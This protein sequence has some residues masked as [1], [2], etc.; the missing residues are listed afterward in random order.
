MRF[1]PPL[2]NFA[3]KHALR[4]A[5]AAAVVVIAGTG[6]L[7]YA[8]GYDRGAGDISLSP[9]NIVNADSTGQITLDDP[10]ETTDF[11]SFWQVWNILN[12]NFVPSS[13]TVSATTSNEARV[14]GAIEGMV[15]SYGDPYTVFIPKE[16]AADFKQEVNGE[17]EGIGAALQVYDGALFISGTVAKSPAEAAGLK[18]GDRILAVDDKPVEG[19]TLDDV[20]NSIRGAAGTTVKLA[21]VAN[22]AKTESDVSV[23]RG[24]VVIPTTA[25]QVVTAAKNVVAAVAAKAASAAGGIETALGLKK[26]QEVADSQFFVLALSTFA[27]SSTD[28][29]VSDLNR[30][31]K[32]GTPYLI[33]DLR[34]NPGG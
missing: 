15:A 30:Y 3:K 8:V 2:K 12:K 11:G 5:C 28:A 17:F 26:A 1:L 6:A 29:F 4:I 21:I 14:A 23:T 34:N 19:Q 9:A 27:K 10:G 7:A 22:G 31:A 24:T 20:V 33:I 18:M 16:Q 13:N 32:S 25:T